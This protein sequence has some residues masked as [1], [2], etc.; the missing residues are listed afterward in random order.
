ML[1]SEATQGTKGNRAYQ[2]CQAG[3]CVCLCKSIR[4]LEAAGLCING[5]ELL[6]DSMHSCHTETSI[7]LM[8]SEASQVA[9]KAVRP[10]RG[11]RLIPSGTPCRGVC[12]PLHSRHRLMCCIVSMCQWV[13]C[14]W[15]C[16]ESLSRWGF[17]EGCWSRPFS[18]GSLEGGAFWNAGLI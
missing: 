4:R 9:A 15:C 10:T 14:W 8:L 17:R 7:S 3:M 16:S 1:L 6:D 12:L 13:T 11:V 18:G 2:G 5:G